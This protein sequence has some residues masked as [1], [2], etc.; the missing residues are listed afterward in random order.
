MVLL[1]IPIPLKMNSPTTGWNS[2]IVPVAHVPNGKFSKIQPLLTQY[3]IKAA[4]DSEVGIGVPSKYLLFPVSSF[5]TFPTV[6]LNRARRVRPQRTKKARR[7][8]STGVRRPMA[9]AAAAGE[10]PKEI[11][12]SI[13]AK[14]TCWGER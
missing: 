7:R 3:A 13:L 14:I 12:V 10:T 11:C 6:M 1:V 8:W 4:I 9:N 2:K 5:G